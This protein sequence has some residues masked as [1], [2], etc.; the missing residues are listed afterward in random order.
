MP[1]KIKIKA[2]WFVPR[3]N[4]LHGTYAQE[5]TFVEVLFLE[6]YVHFTY[7]L[8]HVHITYSQAI[9]RTS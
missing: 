9:N 1:K 7:S 4:H 3:N 2:Y 5:K 8:T 6:K